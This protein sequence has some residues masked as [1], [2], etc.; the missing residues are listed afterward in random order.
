MRSFSC[1]VEKLSRWMQTV[2]GAALVFIVLI[3]V[4]DVCLRNLARQP[5][6]GAYEMVGLAGAIVIGFAIPVTS[7]FKGHIFVDVL[8]RALPK[9]WQKFFNIGTRLL[10]I[11]IFCLISWNLF[12]YANGLLASGEVTLTR[13]L[14]FYPIAYG[15]SVCCVIQGLVLIADIVRIIGGS[16]E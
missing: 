11:L 7:L 6:I 13:R 16:D 3:T 8:I 5:I 12:L 1:I 2:S 10:G 15:L 9:G 14:P 4:A